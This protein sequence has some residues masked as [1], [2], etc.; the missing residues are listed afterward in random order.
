MFLELLKKEFSLNNIVLKF[1]YTVY[2]INDK[3]DINP[4]NLNDKVF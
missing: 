2:E 1:W 4:K 3:R